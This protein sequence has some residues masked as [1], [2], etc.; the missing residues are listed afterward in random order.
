MSQ[1]PGEVTA[2]IAAF[3][4]TI[5]PVTFQDFRCDAGGACVGISSEI[6]HTGMNMQFA[7]RGQAHQTVEPITTS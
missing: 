6:T 1:V 7:V 3:D 4:N 2:A 5:V